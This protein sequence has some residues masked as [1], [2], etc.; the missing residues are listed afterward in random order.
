MKPVPHYILA[1]V[2]RT[3]QEIKPPVEKTPV[4][5]WH[6]ILV[7]VGRQIPAGQDVHVSLCR[8]LK[9]GL[10]PRTEARDRH[11]RALAA[12][13]GLHGLGTFPDWHATAVLLAAAET[14]AFYDALVRFGD[15]APHL[16]ENGRV[17][18]SR[19]REQIAAVFARK[20][21]SYE[22]GLIVVN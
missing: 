9:D 4:A 7:D 8:R 3:V 18:L 21:H 1:F 16:V 15:P 22:S 12:L 17:M 10:G 19:H 6:D 20:L 14:W 11:N 5:F 2:L 13:A